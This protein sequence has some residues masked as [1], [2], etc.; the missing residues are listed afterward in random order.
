MKDLKVLLV[1]IS[2]LGV[3]GLLGM[4]FTNNCCMDGLMSNIILTSVCCCG[5]YGFMELT[6]E[7]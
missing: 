3:M 6:T 2:V 5:A 1:V 4:I 7:D